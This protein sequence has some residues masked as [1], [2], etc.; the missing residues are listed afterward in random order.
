MNNCTQAFSRIVRPLLIIL[1]LFFISE[2]CTITKR[3][4]RKGWHVEWRKVKRTSSDDIAVK[5]KARPLEIDRKAVESSPLSSRNEDIAEKKA[6]LIETT[7]TE[8]DEVSTRSHQD[9]SE[10]IDV[11]NVPISEESSTVENEESKSDSKQQRNW[12]TDLAASLGLTFLI[13]AII[14]AG[15]GMLLLLWIQAVTS[16]ALI[17][18]LGIFMFGIWLFGLFML[19]LAIA[20]FLTAIFG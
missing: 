9:S 8:T 2:S 18:I 7:P 16:S 17:I 3:V 12:H 13:I 15:L 19:I 10:P 20:G 14:F 11:E 5:E 1:I 4:H 6:E